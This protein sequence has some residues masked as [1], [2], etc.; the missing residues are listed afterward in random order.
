MIN[1]YLNE[2]SIRCQFNDVEE[3]FEKFREYTL[4][5]LCMIDKE[6][7][8][9]IW[10][11]DTF[12]DLKI[13]DKI[14]IMEAARWRN[15]NTKTPEMT[16]LK[17][18]IS[19]LFTEEPFFGDYD[20]CDT[21]I[22]EYRFDN[23]YIDKLSNINCFTKALENEGRVVSFFHP[24]Y[25]SDSL[26][27]IAIY[28]GK[29]K[30]YTIDNIYKEEWWKSEPKIER[31]N[32]EGCSRKYKVEIR[33]KEFE[34]HPPHFHVSSK[35]YEAVFNLKN[36]KFWKCG[37]KRWTDQMIKDVEEWYKKE[38]DKLKDIWEK[39]HGKIK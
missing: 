35:E 38:K 4:P 34:Y 24:E 7:E 1:Y 18:K 31:L 12:W 21:K 10:K 17:I 3:F 14:T 33:A 25:I 32:I 37:K 2:Y 22:K 29:E 19:K 15:K 6:E 28:D 16:A 5:V 9:I 27:I 30:E 20:E 8:S 13:C 36:G 23:E 39:L 11:R 26:G